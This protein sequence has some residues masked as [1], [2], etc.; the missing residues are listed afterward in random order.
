[1]KI[2]IRIATEMDARDISYLGMTTFDQ[3]FGHLFPD[4]K[5]LTGYFER[6]FS[7]EKIRSSIQKTA[8]KTK[9]SRGLLFH[10]KRAILASSL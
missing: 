5:D 2:Q 4:R 6:T 10:F 9:S 1:M 8:H 3:S 7:V